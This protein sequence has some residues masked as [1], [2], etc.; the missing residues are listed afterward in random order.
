MA[1]P[2][3]HHRGWFES[4]ESSFL[5]NGHN[6]MINRLNARHDIYIYTYIHTYMMMMKLGT[7]LLLSR[8]N[9]KINSCL[10]NTNIAI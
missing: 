9:V 7:I 2:R 3:Q 8:H 5:G 4:G 10:D 1:L 6:Y